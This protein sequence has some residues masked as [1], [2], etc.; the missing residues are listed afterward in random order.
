V[1]TFAYLIQRIEIFVLFTSAYVFEEFAR[2]FQPFD[3]HSQKWIRTRHAVQA[4]QDFAVGGLIQA[5]GDGTSLQKESQEVN[6]IGLGEGE[7]VG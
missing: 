3:F 2:V 4:V 5:S 6:V 1:I 7:L